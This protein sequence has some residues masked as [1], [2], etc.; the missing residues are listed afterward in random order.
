M[1][2]LNH[3]A[4]KYWEAYKDYAIEYAETCEKDSTRTVN[5]ISVYDYDF[6]EKVIMS[7][8]KLGRITTNVN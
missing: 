4:W 6:A 2:V 5:D 8:K 1:Q 7:T 3:I